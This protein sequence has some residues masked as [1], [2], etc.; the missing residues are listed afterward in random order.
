[1]G[2]FDNAR[3]KAGEF[4][5]SDSGEQ[6]SDQL[7]DKVADAAK[8][9]LGADKAEQ[10]DRVRDAVDDRIGKNDAEPGTA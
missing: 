7:L 8:R 5:N 9:R 3:N 1:M 6:K 10:V 4:L 2:I